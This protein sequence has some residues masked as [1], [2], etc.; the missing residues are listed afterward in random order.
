MSEVEQFY[1]TSYTLK[2]EIEH[3]YRRHMENEIYFQSPAFR[4]NFGIDRDIR[5]MLIT[6]YCKDKSENYLSL[7]LF[8]LG[9]ENEVHLKIFNNK[10]EVVVNQNLLDK[11]I[12][13]SKLGKT[14]PDF[15]Q[16][17]TSAQ[18][19]FRNFTFDSVND[20]LNDDKLTVELEITVNNN[21]T[22]LQKPENLE[23]GKRE[24]DIVET[25]SALFNDD[26]YS[27]VTLVA[28]GKTLKA[29]KCILAKRNSVFAAMFDIDMKEKQKNTVEIEDMKYD[30]LVELIRFIYTEK[31][32][33][34][35]AIVDE[36][37]IAAD[38][39]AV[40][41][42]KKMCEKT[43]GENLSLENFVGCLHLADKLHMNQLKQEVIMFI[44]KNASDISD[45]PEFDS[46]PDDIV[47]QVFRCLAKKIEEIDDTHE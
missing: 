27:D 28:E 6:F 2:W 10:G 26:K 31:V 24:N 39:Y 25:L 34:I 32:N 47:R 41:S 12:G 20:M 40:D 13:V 37:A 45:K 3:F 4:P 5:C 35:V 38:Q 9:V 17:S 19:Y 1:V 30:V 23:V 16:I 29:H 21:K 8:G 33:N 15:E 43:M 36:L 44:F 18:F 11:K 14:F 7:V 46:V 42:L 22:N